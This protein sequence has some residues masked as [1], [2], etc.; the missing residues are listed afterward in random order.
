MR[1]AFNVLAITP[2]LFG[3]RCGQGAIALIR[4]SLLHEPFRNFDS[5]AAFS[6]R[7][8]VRRQQRIRAMYSPLYRAD[9]KTVIRG[10][11]IPGFRA[12]LVAFAGAG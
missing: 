9:S 11:A 1:A 3:D 2:A 4:R 7:R 8:T 12:H 10:P 5:S 6:T